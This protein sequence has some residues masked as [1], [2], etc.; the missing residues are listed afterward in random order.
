ME[1]E[2]PLKKSELSIQRPRRLPTIGEEN[3]ALLQ[4]SEPSSNLVTPLNLKF[5]TLLNHLDTIQ[6]RATN[7]P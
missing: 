4:Q 2:K 3:T 7:S 6:E 5:S 1:E